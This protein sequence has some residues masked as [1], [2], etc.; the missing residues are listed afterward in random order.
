[1]SPWEETGKSTM[2]SA[3]EQGH[4]SREGYAEITSGKTTYQQGLTTTCKDCLYK[5]KLK[6]G[7]GGWFV[8]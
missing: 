3:A 4:S 8:A 2:G 1:M 5:A 7:G 6:A